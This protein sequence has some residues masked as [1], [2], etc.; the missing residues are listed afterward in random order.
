MIP[1]LQVAIGPV[2]LISGVG[3]LL[4]SMTNR[5]GRTVDR[6]RD[7]ARCDRERVAGQ[8]QVLMLRARIMRTAIASAALSVLFASLLIIVLFVGALLQ[9]A[10]TAAVV[11]ALFI[12][13]MVC[14]IVSLVMFIG[15]VNR[16]L[17][18]LKLEVG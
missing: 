3:L 1:T 7:L 9:L 11:G 15:D 10:V 17:K 13:C 5:L 2:I 8:L 18:A 12:A 6:A 16:S 14:L 4:L